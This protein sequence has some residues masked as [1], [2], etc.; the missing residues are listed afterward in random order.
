MRGSLTAVLCPQTP[1]LFREL[2]GLEDPVP[3]LRAA[4][5][6]AVG[7]ALALA[8]DQV[9]VTGVGDEASVVD[10]GLPVDVRRWGTTRP[11][12]GPGLPLSL[13]VGRRLL[14]DASWS[15]ATRLV[16]LSPTADRA[17]LRHLAD[18]LAGIDGDVLLLV[19]GEGSARRD[20]RGPGSLD[21]RAFSY[22]EDLLA[23]LRTGDAAG[24][25]DLDVGLAEALLDASHPALRLWGEVGSAVAG[26]PDAE[27][28]YADDPFGVLYV[29]ATWRWPR[30]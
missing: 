23:A 15:G 1:L 14:E 30:R 17:D 21:E 25:A 4:C 19:L 10:A 29:V 12:T 13:G 7:S 16:G 3:D 18:D 6:A 20:P 11:R 5:A 28:T 24:L 22:D 8:P 2:G 27:V 9:V 26:P